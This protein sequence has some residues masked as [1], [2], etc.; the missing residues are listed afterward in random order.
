MNENINKIYIELTKSDFDVNIK[1][2]DEKVKIVENIVENIIEEQEYEIKQGSMLK[3]EKEKLSNI[4]K[5]IYEMIENQLG[6]I[7]ETI[8]QLLDDNVA[9]YDIM[10]DLG[11]INTESIKKLIIEVETNEI[12]KE[13]LKYII[14]K[15]GDDSWNNYSGDDIQD[16]LDGIKANEIAGLCYLDTNIV[17]SAKRKV[18][19]LQKKETKKIKK[20]TKKEDLQLE[21]NKLNSLINKVSNNKKLEELSDKLLKGLNKINEKRINES[22]EKID[23]NVNKL[24]ENI[25][26]LR[27]EIENASI[28][29]QKFEVLGYESKNGELIDIVTK[30][31]FNCYSEEV[32][33]NSDTIYVIYLS[34]DDIKK[35]SF[36]DEIKDFKYKTFLEKKIKKE[37]RKNKKETKKKETK[38]K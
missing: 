36:K 19:E 17:K 23:K 14:E 22:L 3:Y 10:A 6:P 4:E 21:L 26:K 11:E 25:I 15:N 33:V 38:K 27:E 28:T 16:T 37:K 8:E 32:K 29:A 20:L 9:D 2:I 24:K 31:R 35:V 1:E 5:A 12:Q 30:D 13:K 18:K 7:H 34:N